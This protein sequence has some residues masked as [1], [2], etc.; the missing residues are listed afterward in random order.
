MHRC[1]HSVGNFALL[2]SA[3]YLTTPDLS[4]DLQPKRRPCKQCLK[5]PTPNRIDQLNLS[6][7]LGRCV[8]ISIA[9]H[10][11]NQ[12]HKNST[13]CATAAPKGTSCDGAGSYVS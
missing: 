1:L 13:N 3:C 9:M 11:R 5:L 4:L 12:G 6:A 8:N 2:A 10:Q 7:T